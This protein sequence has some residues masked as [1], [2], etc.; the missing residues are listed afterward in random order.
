MEYE[1]GSRLIMQDV[2]ALRISEKVHIRAGVPV[3]GHVAVPQQMSSLK[4]EGDVV[5]RAGQLHCDVRI[6]V[7]YELLLANQSLSI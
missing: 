6:P 3:L 1:E 2:S 4:T 7:I 5:G